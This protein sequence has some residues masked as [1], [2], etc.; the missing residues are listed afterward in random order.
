MGISKALILSWSVYLFTGCQRADVPEG[1]A[2]GNEG[3]KLRITNSVYPTA[4]STRIP[5]RRGTPVGARGMVNLGNTCF[6]NSDIQILSHSEPLLTALGAHSPSN[7]NSL[8]ARIVDS[9]KK[10]AED[11]W[12]NS[13]G[14]IWSTELLSLLKEL[15]DIFGSG[16]HEDAQEALTHIL[17]ALNDG[18]KE[19]GSLFYFDSRTNVECPFNGYESNRDERGNMLML[20]VPNS[21]VA[22]SLTDSLELYFSAQKH[23]LFECGPDKGE[24]LVKM[25]LRTNPRLLFVHLG[26]FERK[27]DGTMAKIGTPIDFPMNLDISPSGIKA[28]YQLTGIVHHFG[29]M[30][31][32]HYVADFYHHPSKQWYNANDET[33]THIGDK[34]DLVSASAYMF[35]YQLL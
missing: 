3:E 12:T 11:H 2:T 20:G 33:V 22:F 19:I 34:P 7:G 14:P 18:S 35:M 4:S 17:G 30:K 5:G 16:N 23:S 21:D 13:S 29:T 8:S 1:I 26:R 24:A 32:G 31:G 27:S 9:A 25:S 6:F 10:I 15:N 28:K